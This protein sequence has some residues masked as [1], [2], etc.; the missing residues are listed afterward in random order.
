MCTWYR[1]CSSNRTNSAG[2][3]H[4]SGLACQSLCLTQR[5]CLLQVDSLL[6]ID[7]V[8]GGDVKAEQLG[9][10][11]LRCVGRTSFICHWVCC[12]CDIESEVY[13]C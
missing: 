13:V 8:T 9:A 5:L 3:I 7:A 11:F 12:L 2:F 10:R 6:D 1:Q 4:G